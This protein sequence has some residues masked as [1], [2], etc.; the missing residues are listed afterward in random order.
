MW[1]ALVSIPVLGLAVMLQ[2]AIISRVPLLSG[3]ADLILVVLAAWGLQ[4]K[5]RVAWIWGLVAGLMVGFVSA[6]PWY[7]W[8]ISYLGVSAAAQALKRR[9]WQAPLLAMF[10]ITLLGSLVIHMLSFIAIRLSG[11][12][13]PLAEAFTLITLPSTLLNMLLALAVFPIMRDLANWLYPGE[14]YV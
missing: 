3:T 14:E 6:L 12:P 5:V 4:Q 8:L 9:V 7:I 2:L 13:L 10:T 11:N 1:P